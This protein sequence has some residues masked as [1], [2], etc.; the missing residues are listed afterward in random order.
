MRESSFTR[1]MASL[2]AA[3]IVVTASDGVRIAGCLVGFSGQSSIDPVRYT[4]YLSKVNYTYRVARR[5][6]HLMVHFL[7]HDQ[8][9][10]ARHFG[11]LTG[12]DSSK[13]D[14]VRWTAAADG[15]TPRL[16]DC[17]NYLWGRIEH[18]HYGDG[19]HCAFVLEPVSTRAPRRF[20]P[21]R[22]RDVRKLDPGHPVHEK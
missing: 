19:D 11:E 6:T 18:R 2:D 20:D 9:D 10:L 3:M 15:S 1:A 4:V 8:M 12:D 7:A 13:F 21:L 5:S 22:F 17:H 16:T 14:R